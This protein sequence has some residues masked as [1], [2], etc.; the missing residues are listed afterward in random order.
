MDIALLHRMDDPEITL[1]QN[2]RGSLAQLS[3]ILHQGFIDSQP[4]TSMI[5][6]PEPVEKVNFRSRA[7]AL[8]SQLFFV[9]FGLLKAQGLL[10]L[11]AK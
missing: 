1:W 7:T 11:S 8:H 6:L 3:P 10:P 5:S 2:C 4:T 9:S